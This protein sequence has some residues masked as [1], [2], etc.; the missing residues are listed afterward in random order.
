[1]LY[2]EA[3]A[4]GL[5]KDDTI[6]RRRLR[7]KFEFLMEDIEAASAPT[8]RDLQ[9]WMDKNPRRE[10]RSS[11]PG[12][13][14]A[15]GPIADQYRSTAHSRKAVIP[16]SPGMLVFSCIGPRCAIRPRVAVV[17]C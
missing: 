1:V 11:N 4:M 12:A 13:M 6:V 10:L 15:V 9:D 7:Q 2:R 17:R 14:D 8:D 5:D 3:M 16:D